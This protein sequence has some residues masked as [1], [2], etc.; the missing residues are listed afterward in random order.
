[1]SQYD[2]IRKTIYQCEWVVDNFIWKCIR[3]GDGIDI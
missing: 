1:M 2:G 3:L